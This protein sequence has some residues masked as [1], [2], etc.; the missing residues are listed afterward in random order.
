MGKEP[1]MNELSCN[2]CDY[3]SMKKINMKRHAELKH[4]KRSCNDCHKE[5]DSLTILN[6]HI[7][8][9]H[10]KKVPKLKNCK[11]EDCS[12]TTKINSNVRK[13]ELICS[14]RPIELEVVSWF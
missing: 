2:F 8:Q 6:K 9:I 13:H 12:Y 3:K 4:I 11:W 7:R 1:K 5:F 14:R 10:I